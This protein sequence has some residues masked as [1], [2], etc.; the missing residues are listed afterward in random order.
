MTMELEQLIEQNPWWSERT[1]IQ[2]DK[3]IREAYGASI[4]W[5]PRIRKFFALDKDAIYTL[6]GPRQVGK[7]TLVK[8]LI[9]ELLFPPSLPAKELPPRAVFY[10]TCEQIDSKNDLIELIELY[11]KFSNV[12]E[13]GQRRYM[14]IDEIST[15]KNWEIALK[16]LI[17][18]DK[19]GNVTAV[20]TGSHA[21][22]LKRSTERLP[23]RRGEADGP[24]NK[25]FLPMKFAEYVGTVRP[26]LGK[27]L[28][29]IFPREREARF[30]TLF[31]LFEGKI[32]KK[33]QTE[34][35]LYAK[36]TRE[37]LDNYLIT[38]GVMKAI[39]EFYEK[40]AI[41][42]VTYEIYVQW[43]LGDL[44]KWNYDENIT[45]QVLRSTVNKMTTRISAHSIAKENEIKSHNTVTR[46]MGALESSFVLNLQYPID[47][48]KNQAN[49]SREKKAY[50]TD[51]FI[52]HAIR[53]WTQG[54]PDYFTHA[55][56][57][58]A[59]QGDKSNLIEMVVADHLRRWAYNMGPSD[60]FTP[61]EKV[62]FWKKKGKKEKEID[63]VLKHKDHICPIEVK[64]QNQVTKRDF[65]NFAFTFNSGVLLS[66]QNME[67]HN[68]YSILPVEAFLLLI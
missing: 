56:D 27:Q 58:I 63:F 50:F 35:P 5:D 6:R 29:E 21:L 2:T 11:M 18:T 15:V 52:Y 66:K 47:L 14:F 30:Q 28:R 40:V 64:Y 36:E 23:G 38:G 55:Q 3:K 34:Y 33:I 32:D 68:R 26:K 41:T 13:K 37:L 53:G 45:R 44:R 61:H 7:T 59:K 24:M 9:N 60:V 16:H 54:T 25:I 65:G 46:Y 12:L 8:F 62:M 19:M 42:N 49:Y 1:A 17:D 4:T 43:L 31:D 22:D 20:L 10:F 57:A 51:P 67:T 48:H 39:N